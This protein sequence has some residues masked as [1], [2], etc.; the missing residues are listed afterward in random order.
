MEK[1]KHT[2]TKIDFINSIVKLRSNY[3]EIGVR[4]GENFFAIRSK[5]KVGVDPN[6][7]FSRRFYLKSCCKPYNWNYKMY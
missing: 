3:I 2:M 7:F 6:Y 4:N 1:L 5:N